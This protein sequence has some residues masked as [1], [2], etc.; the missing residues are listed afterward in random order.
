MKISKHSKIYIYSAKYS[1]EYILFG[2]DGAIPVGKAEVKSPQ[3]CVD[4]LR[5]SL[6][7][8]II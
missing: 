7:S 4:A 8:K 1:N 6:G 3:G 2:L 5:L